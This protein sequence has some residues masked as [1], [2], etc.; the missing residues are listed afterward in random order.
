MLSFSDVIHFWN[1]IYPMPLTTINQN[2][3]ELKPSIS[4]PHIRPLTTPNSAV[5]FILSHQ[6]SQHKL[7][8]PTSK[9]E[10]ASSLFQL[11]K[12]EE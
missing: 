2:S 10:R 7:Q 11:T 5:V 4:Q 6:P 9:L 1:Q 8:N 12:Y 3:K